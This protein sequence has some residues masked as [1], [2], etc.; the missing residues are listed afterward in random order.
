MG[1]TAALLETE[2][3]VPLGPREKGFSAVYSSGRSPAALAGLAV[4]TDRECRPNT[5]LCHLAES[6]HVRGLSE[7]L[8]PE[9]SFLVLTCEGLTFERWGTGAFKPRVGLAVLLLLSAAQTD[10]ET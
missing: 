5:A 9:G 3:P 7:V 6:Q 4:I 8:S 2:A 1:C 10:S